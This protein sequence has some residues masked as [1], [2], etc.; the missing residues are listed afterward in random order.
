MVHID[1]PIMDK[2]RNLS[3]HVKNKFLPYGIILL[4]VGGIGVF[5]DD[6]SSVPIKEEEKLAE[7][8]SPPLCSA[9]KKEAGKQTE[10]T[11]V[12]STAGIARRKPLPD[13]FV[14]GTAHESEQKKT[15]A[16]MTEK[17]KEE[18]KKQPV[19][20]LV[21]GRFVNEGAYLV[22]LS[23]TADT[24]VCAIDE[25]FD[26]FRIVLY[27]S[28][29]KKREGNGELT[30][31]S[32]IMRKKV[33]I[34]VALFCLLFGPGKGY[35]A[36]NIQINAHDVPLRTVLEGLGRSAG[37]N[38][39]IDDSVKGNITVYLH[40]VSA[41]EALQSVIHE[42]GLCLEEKNGIFLIEGTGEGQKTVSETVPLSYMKAADA[43]GVAGVALRQGSVMAVGA[44]NAIVMTGR[45]S[46]VTAAKR[47]IQAVDYAPQQVDVEAEILSLNKEAVKELGIDWSWSEGGGGV[48][49]PRLPYIEARLHAFV[50]DGKASILA[51]PHIMATNG[52]EARIFI[53][54]RIPVVTERVAGGE[55]YATTEYK[56][57]GILLQ[58]TPYIHTDGTVTANI[59]GEV[60]MP[61][62]V[63]DLRAYRVAT[64]QVDTQ[65]H[66][67]AGERIVIG[68]LIG[69]EETEN[70][71]KVPI[72]GDLP[73]I[74]KLFRSRYRSKKETEVIIII[75]SVILPPAG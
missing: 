11:L 23:S 64:R 10:G 75:K 33:L 53:G 6:R 5:Y 13:L 45:H 52:T 60:G 18:L 67:K 66:I 54:D 46:D 7:A 57:A 32:G 58:Y 15:P 25:E 37:M 12:F 29:W 62:Y 73:L 31:R 69:K 21:K 24:R 19:L 35:C 41:Q 16:G 70:L 44:S 68:G 28:S 59:H 4:V 61:V 38:I 74:G 2:V 36:G 14:T 65:V 72:L 34:A 3:I 48:G 49:K 39:L 50:S 22:I 27:P 42:A 1:K 55:R 51:K 56:E 8:S 47:L 9:P 43:A 26:G 30:D 17:A 71:R 63:R 20:P 40:N